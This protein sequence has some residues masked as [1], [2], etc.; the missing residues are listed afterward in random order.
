MRN[1]FIL[2]IILSVNTAHAGSYGNV[3]SKIKPY[4]PP[5]VYTQE[6]LDKIDKHNQLVREKYREDVKAAELAELR[7]N[8]NEKTTEIIL[9]MVKMGYSAINISGC[10]TWHMAPDNISQ[11][12]AVGGCQQALPGLGIG[13]SFQCRTCSGD[14]TYNGGS[15]KSQNGVI[16][17]GLI[18]TE[19]G[20]DINISPSVLSISHQSLG[21]R[22]IYRI[23]DLNSLA[24]SAEKHNKTAKY[25]IIE[26]SI[27]SVVSQITQYIHNSRGNNEST[28]STYKIA[29]KVWE[30]A[31]TD[32]IDAITFAKEVIAN[33]DY[34]EQLI[35]NFF[36]KK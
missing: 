33:P 5:K 27:P 2:L 13:G 31:A 4:Q 18:K 20:Y 32:G 22:I 23:N 25:S 14:W 11:A 6:E 17:N 30:T 29:N 7:R 24:Y 16:T 9:N 1:L 28:N 8:G 21:Y 12:A 10:K 35:N 26:I 3:V 34:S 36:A 15:F 19:D